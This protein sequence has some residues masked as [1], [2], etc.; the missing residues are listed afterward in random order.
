MDSEWVKLIVSALSGLAAAI[1]LVYQ[2]IKYVRKAVK[3][4]NWPKVVELVVNLMS[5]VE[6][7]LEVG[8]DKK[9]YVMASLKASADTIDYDL[10]EQDYKK[11][12]D[13]IDSMCTMSKIVNGNT[14]NGK[15]AKTK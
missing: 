12:S 6:G 7:K 3:D 4:K 11:I 8:A 2:L 9:A 1:P 5:E 14:A 13:L 10:D 15:A